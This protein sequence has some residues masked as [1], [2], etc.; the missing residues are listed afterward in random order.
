MYITVFNYL[1]KS[2]AWTTEYRVQ[3]YSSKT[4]LKNSDF[5]VY[6]KN[7]RIQ[8]ILVTNRKIRKNGKKIHK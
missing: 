5:Y 1:Y 7:K 8:L 4:I 3:S 6:F 2:Y